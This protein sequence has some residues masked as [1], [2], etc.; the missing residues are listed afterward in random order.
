[1]IPSST[2]WLKKMKKIKKSNLDLEA[3]KAER[4]ISDILSPS[5]E[6]FKKPL[7]RTLQLLNW[8]KV[9][10]LLLRKII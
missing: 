9:I 3:K 5:A 7:P 4:D 2:F 6:K 1:M 10:L 8:S